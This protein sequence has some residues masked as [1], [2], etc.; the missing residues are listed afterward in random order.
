MLVPESVRKGQSSV[1][2]A[3]ESRNGLLRDV[4]HSASSMSEEPFVA[5]RDPEIGLDFAQIGR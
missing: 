3:A 4:E 5:V 1:L 2:R